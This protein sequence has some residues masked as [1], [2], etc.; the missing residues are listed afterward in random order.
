MNQVV[1]L[2]K[3]GS[4]VHS[5]L[6]G[7]RDGTVVAIHGEQDP[8]S[9]RTVFDGV[10]V[11]GGRARF[12]I[13]WDD[14]SMSRAI[15]ESLIRSSSQWSILNE[16]VDDAAVAE[17]ISR[18]ALEKARREAEAK[19][20]KEQF[21]AA[22]KALHEGHSKL[23]KMGP[24]E[25]LNGTKLVAAN[26]R[27]LFKE[28]FPK[29]KFSIRTDYNSVR[30]EWTD[31][32]TGREVDE[33]ADKFKAGKFDGMTDSYEF[34]A[35]PWGE[36][37]GEAMYLFTSRNVSDVLLSTCL[38]KLWTCSLIEGN[39]KQCRK[40]DIESIRRG[41]TDSVPN[42]DCTVGDIVYKLARQ[43][44]MVTGAFVSSNRADQ[45]SYLIKSISMD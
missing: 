30:I 39:L 7:G 44:N 13:V 36:V 42:L 14:S 1:E 20:A 25:P 43:Y 17:A 6:Y 38:D 45:F 19:L 32:P 9:C 10:G 31:G 37:F 8:S 5:I 28:A 12:D 27:I 2:L 41:V 11:T 33:I 24:D 15:P 4:R 40:P 22:K 18:A 29:V 26:L 34:K 16:S 21:E 35:T 3:T 23:R